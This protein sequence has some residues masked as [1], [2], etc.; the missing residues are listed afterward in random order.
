[1]TA[2]LAVEE[3]RQLCERIEKERGT[4]VQCL[5]AGTDMRTKWFA[6]SLG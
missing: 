2:I 6:N 3:K 5:K 1:M 4:S